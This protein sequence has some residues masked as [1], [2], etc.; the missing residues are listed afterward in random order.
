[1]HALSINNVKY[2]CQQNVEEAS[3]VGGPGMCSVLEDR[4]AE[5]GSESALSKSCFIEDWKESLSCWEVSL[6]VDLEKQTNAQSLG[7]SPA[8]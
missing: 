5:C 7:R 6:H 2:R 8:F 4:S 1:M 3:E